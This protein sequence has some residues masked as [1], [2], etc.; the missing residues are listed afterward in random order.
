MS[1]DL[2]AGEPL[3]REGDVGHEF[4]IIVDGKATVS[5]GGRELATLGPGDFFGELALL[6]GHRRNAT[7][8]SATPLD[9]LCVGQQEFAALLSD[10][11]QLSRKL[12][13]GMARRLHE[14]DSRV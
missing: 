3:V 6:D 10:L 7:V 5:R 9:V 8:T 11:P 14:L 13:T 2:A 1:A 12:L 4:Y